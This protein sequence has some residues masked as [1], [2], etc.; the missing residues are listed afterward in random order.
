MVLRKH[1]FKG[2]SKNPV[3][4][5][6]AKN[7]MVNDIQNLFFAFSAQKVAKS[8]SETL[9]PDIEDCPTTEALRQTAMAELAA[10][11]EA[12][13]QTPPTFEDLIAV[14]GEVYYL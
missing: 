13:G 11:Y 7:A 12:H 5:E 6:A 4:E 9:M 10:D 2:L 8:L 1:G 14:V 3:A